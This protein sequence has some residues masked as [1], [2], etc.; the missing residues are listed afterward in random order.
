[1]E[2]MLLSFHKSNSIRESLCRVKCAPV[3]HCWEFEYA[4]FWEVST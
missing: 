2:S 3:T 1:M 4:R